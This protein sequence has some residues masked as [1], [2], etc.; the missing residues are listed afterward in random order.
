MPPIPI[1]GIRVIQSRGFYINSCSN[2][3]QSN[4]L[5]N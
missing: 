5:K 3:Y 2:T 1:G 4:G